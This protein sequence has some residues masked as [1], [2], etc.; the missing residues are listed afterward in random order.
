MAR[1]QEFYNI[2]KQAIEPIFQEFEPIRRKELQKVYVVIAVVIILSIIAIIYSVISKVHTINIWFLSIFYGSIVFFCFVPAFI[3]WRNKVFQKKLKSKALPKLLKVFGDIFPT[4]GESYYTRNKYTACD[5][6]F[7]GS[8]K[9]VSFSINEERVYNEAWQRFFNIVSSHR[10]V[11][12]FKFNKSI[13]GHVDVESEEQNAK[14][15]LSGVVLFGVCAIFAVLTVIMG[16]KATGRLDCLLKPAVKTLVY[17]IPTII[18]GIG[19]YFI[20]EKLKVKLEDVEFEKKYNTYSDDQVEAR[21]I[22]T[23]SFMER[24]KNLETVF[25]T[26]QLS[27]NIS[28]SYMTITIEP[29][30][31]LF[32]I[33]SLFTSL[34]DTKSIVKFYKELTSILDMIDTFKLDE[35]TGL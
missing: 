19:I 18:G 31:D 30:D 4:K 8:Y 6:A 12:K 14:G 15:S 17:A 3:F 21:Y 20:K 7:A 10:V 35:R 16:F 23:P 24:L 2:Y 22:L 25:G 32:E 5:D 33:G 26:N 34:K 29:E 28:G 27:C 9:D 13:K 11:I 1:A